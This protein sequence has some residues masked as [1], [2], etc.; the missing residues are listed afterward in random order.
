MAQL[1]AKKHNYEVDAN[2]VS[3]DTQ[4]KNPLGSWNQARNTL[5]YFW[6]LR[7]T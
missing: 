7:N 3:K 1:F 6:Q 2:Q 5:Q 4:L